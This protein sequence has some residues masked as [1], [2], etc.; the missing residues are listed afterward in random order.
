MAEKKAPRRTQTVKKAPETPPTKGQARAI[1][2]ALRDPWK[3]LDVSGEQHREQQQKAWEAAQAKAEIF[4][5]C[6]GTPAG[7]KVL[8]I[9]RL[10]TIEQP[11][12]NATTTDRGAALREGQNSWQRFVEKQ[13]QLAHIGTPRS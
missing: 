11:I 5:Q 13:V 7:K 3:D 1:E 8:E 10:M 12:M 6:F 2:D 4:S 9:M